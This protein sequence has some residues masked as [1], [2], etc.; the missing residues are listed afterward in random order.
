MQL[1]SIDASSEVYIEHADHT[2]GAA[3]AWADSP[4]ITPA[5]KLVVAEVATLVGTACTGLLNAMLARM[6]AERAKFKARAKF[7]VCDVGLDFRL[8][9]AG[10]AILNGPALREREHTVFQGV[11]SKQ[12]PGDIAR[13]DPREEP[14]LV[15]QVV[16]N[17]NA[18]A[19][20]EGKAAVVSNLS[21]A[22]STSVQARDNLDSYVAAENQ[23][24]NAELQ[25]RLNVRVALEQA[26][27]KLRAAFPGQRAFVESFFLKRKR[28]EGSKKPEAGPA[29]NPA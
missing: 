13:S 3:T 12:N 6:N 1:P 8:M 5:Q 11:F 15:Q 25:A 2:E 22:V 10:D 21:A 17:I 28:S 4:I 26:Y 9:G 23:A 7:T 16:D 29:Q 14:E 20:F 24:A 19:D 27:G 18:L